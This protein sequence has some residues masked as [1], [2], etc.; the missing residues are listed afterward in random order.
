VTDTNHAQE[1]REWLDEAR[2]GRLKA[3]E[4]R[5]AKAHVEALSAEVASAKADNAALLASLRSITWMDP[6]EDARCYQ[7]RDFHLA[8][9]AMAKRPHP[10]AALLARL[11]KLEKGL[12]AVINEA[13]QKTADAL[14]R[15][16]EEP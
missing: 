5:K 16:L 12:A 6:K 3:D 15:L 7:G 10:G 4:V 11:T 9:E 13:D 14:I 8:A 1:L 2:N